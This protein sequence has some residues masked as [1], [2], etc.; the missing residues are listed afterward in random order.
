MEDY[1]VVLS[2]NP[3]IVPDARFT[4]SHDCDGLRVQFIYTGSG[5]PDSLLWEFSDGM[6]AGGWQVVHSFPS[7]YPQWVRLTVFNS[8]EVPQEKTHFIIPTFLNFI[9]VRR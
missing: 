3:G 8:W 2:P 7:Q 4:Y 9:I 1:T 5:A 6:Q